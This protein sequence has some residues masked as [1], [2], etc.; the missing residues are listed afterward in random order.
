MGVVL[1]WVFELMA[2]LSWTLIGVGVEVGMQR[3]SSLDMTLFWDSECGTELPC[4]R[5]YSFYFYF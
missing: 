2:H 3:E 1:L 4:W 5:G